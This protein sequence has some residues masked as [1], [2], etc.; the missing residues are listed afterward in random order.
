MR[1]L[2]DAY[3]DED[4][5]VCTLYHSLLSITVNKSWA[6]DDDDASAS[7]LEYRKATSDC[8]MV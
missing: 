7:L 1:P 5:T 3:E 6:C 8:S 2:T 4:D